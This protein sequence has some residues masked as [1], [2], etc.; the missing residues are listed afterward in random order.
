MKRATRN[1][2][3]IHVAA[4]IVSI[5]ILAPFLWMVVASITPQRVL[6]TT[7]LQWIP[8]SWDFSRYQTIFQGG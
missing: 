7:P 1:S 3:L 5:V 8:D 6:I 2:I 4:I